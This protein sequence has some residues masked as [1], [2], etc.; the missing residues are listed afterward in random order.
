MELIHLI[1]GAPN[2]AYFKYGLQLIRAQHGLD[3][4][5]PT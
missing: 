4:L 1:D 3:V 2:E 5:E